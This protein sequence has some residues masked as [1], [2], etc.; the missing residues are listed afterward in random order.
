MRLLVAGILIA[1]ATASFPSLAQDAAATASTNSE[2]NY[3]LLTLGFN[4]ILTIGQFLSLVGLGLLSRAALRAVLNPT[5]AQ[6]EGLKPMTIGKF[7]GGVAIVSLLYFPMHAMMMV[8]DVTGLYNKS[9]GLEMCVMVDVSR[10]TS[11]WENNAAKC[12]QDAETRVESMAQ[13]GNADHIKSANLEI[14]YGVIQATGLIFFLFSSWTLLQHMI[15]H[16]ELRLSIKQ[17]L[18]SMVVASIMFASPNIPAYIEDYK[19]NQN[20]IIST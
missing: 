12:L 16:R 5:L 4:I 13:Y 7:M 6:Q 19:S 3:R 10:S 17:C 14:F 1:A 15:G 20:G 8:N 2:Y 11:G 18:L 9:A